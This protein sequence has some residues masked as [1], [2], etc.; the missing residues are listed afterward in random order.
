MD[1]CKASKPGPHFEAGPSCPAER[2]GPETGL[3]AR[4]ELCP[5]QTPL[6]SSGPSAEGQWLQEGGPE[7]HPQDHP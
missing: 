3:D 2:A 5:E 1:L 7:R 4:L 6:L